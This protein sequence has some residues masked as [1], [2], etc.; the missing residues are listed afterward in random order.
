MG[1]NKKRVAENQKRQKF[2]SSTDL[3]DSVNMLC[4]STLSALKDGR[5]GDFSAGANQIRRI[6]SRIGRF[7]TEM[8]VTVKETSN[9][10]LIIDST[11]EENAEQASYVAQRV[12]ILFS[13][14]SRLMELGRTDDVKVLIPYIERIKAKCLELEIPNL[15]G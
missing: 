12:E 10:N 4:Q 9:E 2:A 8:S 14:F 6:S 15:D 1:F 13:S 3:I 5:K 11:P 7:G